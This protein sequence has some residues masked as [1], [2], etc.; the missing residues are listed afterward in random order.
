MPGGR[1]RAG[2]GPVE[3]AVEASGFHTIGTAKFD[4]RFSPP[5]SGPHPAGGAPDAGV[6]ED[7]IPEPRQVAA[8][9]VGL[10]LLHYAPALPEEQQQQL[11]ELG[12]GA[13]EV[14]VAP[15]AAPID[16][17]KQV[18]LTAWEQRQ[19]CTGVDEAV[20]GAFIRQFAGRGLAKG[21]SGTASG[22]VPPV[23]CQLGDKAH[24]VPG[25]RVVPVTKAVLGG[26]VGSKGIR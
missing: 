8:T 20:V 1:E 22:P 26:R 19:L 5:A 23:Q 12:R 21:P 25:H 18:A 14:I 17:G 13:E 3:W 6:Y 24:L 15:A 16:D 4:Y 10:V 9:E 7:P 11:A 2:C